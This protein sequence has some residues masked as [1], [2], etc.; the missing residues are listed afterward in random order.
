MAPAVALAGASGRPPGRPERPLGPERLWA[1]ALDLIEAD[2]AARPSALRSCAGGSV[3][4]VSNIRPFRRRIEHAQ[5]ERRARS[6]TP[7]IVPALRPPSSR[8]PVGRSLAAAGFGVAGVAAVVVVTTAV[9]N[10]QFVAPLPETAVQRPWGGVVM[11][12][13]T[14]HS[15][16]HSVALDDASPVVAVEISAANMPVTGGP[17]PSA[18]T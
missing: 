14:D 1:G 5:H 15:V 7:E 9:V 13:T 18:L 16:V 12:T 3:V 10:G 8:S 4:V 6:A 2:S 17:P 11:S